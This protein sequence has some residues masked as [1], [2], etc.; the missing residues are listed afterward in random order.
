MFLTFVVFYFF[1]YLILVFRVLSETGEMILVR[2]LIVHLEWRIRSKRIF[3]ILFFLVELSFFRFCEQQHCIQILYLFFFILT[4]PVIFF[5]FL[6]NEHRVMLCFIW[7]WLVCLPPSCSRKEYFE[8][9]YCYDQH[10][11]NDLIFSRE[12]KPLIFG[13]FEG[14]NPTIIACGGR[15]TGKTNVI[16]VRFSFSWVF[17]SGFS[18]AFINWLSFS[19]VWLT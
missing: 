18:L 5:R 10:E 19:D 2:L 6:I 8:V 14:C 1:E 17:F 12:I 3:T 7:G 16:Q 9:D 13:V 4:V 11:E 15:L